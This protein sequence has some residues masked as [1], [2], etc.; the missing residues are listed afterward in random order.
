MRTGRNA[1]RVRRND[2]DQRL[3]LS[4]PDRLVTT[5]RDA[6]QHTA[7]VAIVTVGVVQGV[8][9][10]PE[11]KITQAPPMVNDVFGLGQVRIKQV[12]DATALGIG[13]TLD[14]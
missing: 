11:D 14:M 4:R 2:P 12:Q 3:A 6:V 10:V 9:V 13:D 5:Q 8:P 1:V 7:I